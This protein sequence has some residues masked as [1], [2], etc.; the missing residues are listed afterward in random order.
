MN[1]T[2]ELL[3]SYVIMTDLVLLSVQRTVLIFIFS[4]KNCFLNFLTTFLTLFDFYLKLLVT[5]IRP[6]HH[7][8][9][10]F[11]FTSRH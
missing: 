2:N 9:K 10:N 8:S 6:D 4:S 7:F 11:G 5:L 1:E 3:Y